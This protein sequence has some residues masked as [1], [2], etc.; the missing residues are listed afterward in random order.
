MRSFTRAA[1]RRRRNTPH[2]VTARPFGLVLAVVVGLGACSDRTD[3]EISRLRAENER[4]RAELAEARLAAGSASDT[5][6]EDEPTVE[7]AVDAINVC[8][9]EAAFRENLIAAGRQYPD[10][11]RLT[12]AIDIERV[13]G[14]RIGG[15]FVGT[16][17]PVHAAGCFGVVV[18]FDLETAATFRAG[19]RIVA[20]CPFEFYWAGH[21]QWGTCTLGTADPPAWFCACVTERD[22][23]EAATRDGHGEPIG[24]DEDSPAGTVVTTCRRGRGACDRVVARARRGGTALAGLVADCTPVEGTDRP[25]LPLEVDGELQPSARAGGWQVRGRCAIAGYEDTTGSNGGDDQ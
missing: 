14:E 20:R 4:L 7:A 8:D 12:V 24:P 11:T 23:P 1:P 5:T 18:R 15:E 13:R 22:A 10:G 3:A 9:V 21:T 17:A 16:V 2:G 6:A 19:Q 25:T